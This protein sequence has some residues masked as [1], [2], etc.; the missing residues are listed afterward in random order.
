MVASQAPSN[1]WEDGI[2]AFLYRW[3]SRSVQTKPI[4]PTGQDWSG[5]HAM[6][7][8]LSAPLQAARTEG[9]MMNPW[10][11]AGIGRREVRNAAVLAGLWRP[12]GGGDTAVAFLDAFLRRI[13]QRE[14][15]ALPTREQLEQGYSVEVEN[16]PLGA[17]SERIDLTIE[18]KPFMIGIEV[19]IEAGLGERQLERY[20]D[21]I[22]TRAELARQTPVI[23]FLSPYATREEGIVN[24][25]WHDV[26]AA[27]RSLR[28]GEAPSFNQQLIERFAAH[29]STF[30]KRKR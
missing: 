13:E 4:E 14:G 6:L 26:A 16:C 29:V 5:I 21:A 8:S 3:P 15:I 19:K 12:A 2:C 11:L 25:S 24:T 27:A 22:R 10:A 23:L 20:R 28:S 1:G 17:T 30:D 18:C 7:T 9:G